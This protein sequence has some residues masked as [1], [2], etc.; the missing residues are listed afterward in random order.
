MVVYQETRSRKSLMCVCVCVCVCVSV[1]VCVGLYD[2]SKE[3]ISIFMTAHRRKPVER[4]IL[5]I[6]VR[7]CMI[8]GTS[9]QKRG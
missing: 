5:K 9:S 4:K 2:F 7:N 1:C 3:N 6:K 8:I